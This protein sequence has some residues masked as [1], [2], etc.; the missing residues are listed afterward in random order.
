MC[1]LAMLVILYCR[2]FSDGPVVRTPSFHWQE[3]GFN[4]WSRS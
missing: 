4:P 1:S 2:N 3:A